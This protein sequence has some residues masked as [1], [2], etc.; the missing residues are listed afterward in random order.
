VWVGRKI[1]RLN[2]RARDANYSLCLTCGC[3][4]NG[5][6]DKHRCPECGTP[7]EIDDVKRKWSEYLADRAA[8]KLPW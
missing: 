2:R 5:L 3:C 8:R 6:P 7:Y 1:D 4:L